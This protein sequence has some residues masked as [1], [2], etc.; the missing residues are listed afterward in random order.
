MLV[1][2]RCS[3]CGKVGSRR[4][5]KYKMPSAFFCS[6][7]CQNEWQKTREDLVLKNKDSEFRRKVSVGLKRRKQ[8]LGER[9]HSAETKRKIGDAT[10][11]RWQEYAQDKRNHLIEVLNSNAENKRTY[12]SYDS[13][14]QRLSKRLRSENCY[15]CGKRSQV[16]HHIIPVK[17]GGKTELRNLVPLC[18][19]CHA[20]IEFAQKELYKIVGDWETVAILVKEQ[21]GV[22]NGTKIRN[23][24]R[25]TIRI[26]IAPQ[27][28][29]G[30]L[31]QYVGETY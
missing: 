4:Y 2:Y 22:E 18:I 10:V 16:T 23:K 15:R 3:I 6:R 17:E 24:I 13:E 12:G 20:K 7:I 1:N 14:W 11:A 27:E 26:E 19:G 28:P 29:E 8:V 25:K 9:Y 5:V 21:L 30:T 31:R